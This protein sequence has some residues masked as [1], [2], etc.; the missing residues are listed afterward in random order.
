MTI[1]TIDIRAELESFPWVR[2]RWE[3]DKLIAASP[4]RYDSAPSFYVYLDDNPTTGARAGDWGDSGAIDPEW[5]RGGVVKLLSFLRDETPTETIEYLRA[6]YS[7]DD[8]DDTP[9]TGPRLADDRPE[10]KPL[11]ATI[12]D[13]Y[14]GRST[15]LTQRGI[16]ESVQRLMRVGYAQDRRA[17]TIPWFNANGTLGTVLYRRADSKVF[18][19][20]R[21]CPSC[22]SDRMFREG[23][24]YNCGAC[25]H[26]TASPIDGRALREMIYGIDVVYSRNVKRAV[27]VEAPIDALT[28]MSAGVCG[29]ATGGTA[30]GRAKRDLIVRSTLKEVIIIR[31]NDVAGR[32]WQRKVV[33]EL[34]EHLDVKISNVPRI[35]KDVN[36]MAVKA[37]LAAVKERVERAKPVNRLHLVGF[38]S[39]RSTKFDLAK[40]GI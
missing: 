15:Y 3:A 16:S 37:G 5:E 9:L 18:W 22:R 31:D 7:P 23:A 25:G 14:N 35:Y 4:F 10:Y 36:E 26:V 1:S 38:T 27:I 33:T 20:I 19:Y 8:N 6:R 34:R 29:I 28:I 12:L 13:R 11:D 32:E 30:F 17:V 24:L 40:L 21:I 2:P 39:G